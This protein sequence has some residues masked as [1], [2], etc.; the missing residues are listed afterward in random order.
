MRDNMKGLNYLRDENMVSTHFPSLV[1]WH[2]LLKS[3]PKA[4]C[5]SNGKG[6][7]LSAGPTLGNVN[8]EWQHACHTYTKLRQDSFSQRFLVFFFF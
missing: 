8:M 3:N 2:W 5:R 4:V 1:T 6:A 7:E